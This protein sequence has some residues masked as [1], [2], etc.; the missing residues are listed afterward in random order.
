M[1][2]SAVLSLERFYRPAGRT[3][4]AK[5]RADG[6]RSALLTSQPSF[7]AGAA[8][9]E[10]TFAKVGK[11]ASACGAKLFC[12]SLGKGAFALHSLINIKC[13]DNAKYLHQ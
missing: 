1:G 3:C 6:G 12:E 13:V 2:A 9:L 11:I 5:E 8:T 7:A 10:E 4:T